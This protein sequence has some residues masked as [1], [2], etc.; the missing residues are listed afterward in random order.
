MKPN[1]ALNITDTAISLLHRTSRGWLEVGSANFDA[2]D[3][4]EAL[5][6][7]RASALG[8]S[9]HGIT[10]K[11]ILPPGQ[12]LYTEVEVTGV[13]KAAREVEIRAALEG[14][15]PYAVED[16]V[17][18]WRGTG[19]VVKVAV[20]ARE[21]LEEAEAFAEAHRFNAVSFVTLPTEG[22]F[23]GEPWFG[24]T[25]GAAS[26]L[27]EGEKVTR[28][29][30][31][32]VV[33]SREAP[34]DTTKA[35][36]T[37][38]PVV[39]APIAEPVDAPKAEAAAAQ[40]DRKDMAEEAAQQAEAEKAAEQQRAEREKAEVRRLAD[41]Q[42]AEAEARARDKADADARAE[43]EAAAEAE[44]LRKGEIARAEMER[45]AQELA[46]AEAKRLVEEAEKN[47]AA[48]L[49]REKSKA[50]LIE[51][52]RK[53]A[54]SE[55]AAAEEAAAAFNGVTDPGIAETNETAPAP[56][57]SFASRRRD[58][59]TSAPSLGPATGAVA[60]GGAGQQLP[61]ITSA[62]AGPA[63]E[64]RI[65]RPAGNPKG[66]AAPAI[67]SIAARG[68]DAPA[69]S[70][71]KPVGTAAG[72]G[73]TAGPAAGPAVA[74]KPLNG[75][76][77]FATGAKAEVGKTS[78]AAA[79]AKPAAKSVGAM[80]TAATIPGTSMALSRFKSKLKAKPA[81]Q[82]A[83]SAARKGSAADVSLDKF[84]AKMTP[85][86]G[87]PRF[88]GLILTL[89]LL[90]L[91]AGVAAWSSIYLSRDDTAPQTVQQA[92]ATAPDG[93]PSDTP[94]DTPTGSGVSDA[95]AVADAEAELPPVQTVASAEEAAAPALPDT[96]AGD[97]NA[98]TATA[99]RSAE[100][101]II[102]AAIDAAQPAFDPVA[103]PRPQTRPDAAP[104]AVSPPP[105]FG[106]QYEFEPD[107]T[108]KATANGVVMPD[109]FW[110]IAARPPVLPPARPAALSD[111]DV[112]TVA[113]DANAAATPPPAPTDPAG[114]STAGLSRMEGTVAG[115]A[116]TTGEGTVSAAGPSFAFE[117]DATVE[118]RR[119]R[120]R[121][122]SLDAVAPA[123]A[124]DDAA[125]TPDAVVA[126]PALVRLASLRPRARPK[127]VV[128]AAEEAR[129]AAVAASL[130]ATAAAEEKTQQDSALTVALSPRP[131]ARPRDF[132]RA[133][134]AAIAAATREA[135]RRVAAAAAAP[136]PKAEAP[137][138]IEEEHEPELKVSAA[139]RIPTHAN[140]AKQATFKS[141][142]NLSKTNLIGVYGSD[143]KRY[144]LIRSA[145]GRYTKVRVGDKVD[146]GT[147]AAITRNEVRYQKGG[148]M[149]SLSMPKG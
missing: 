58:D 49:E 111:P 17:F 95:E 144:A 33:I 148:K 65:D 57:A 83:A 82:P 101:E 11:L 142:I 21:T 78:D 68:P 86:R 104:A 29:Q 94:T 48:M 24:M 100:D 116:N 79:R 99:P 127:A 7:L 27:P 61:K 132:S 120:L 35:P 73:E 131:A 18:D 20:V 62:V 71:P 32:V 69:P 60:G 122:E 63:P 19:S 1:F 124:Q 45:R 107:G 109:G 145:S 96:V 103:L 26:I 70:G 36:E 149:L 119:P 16:L 126:D 128:A 74:R 123:P 143:K 77:A 30:D 28:D 52:E 97:S 40:D 67:T 136:A 3:L 13:D 137:A 47:K 134:E 66:P 87:K 90:G 135:P 14:R 59:A 113:P 72:S 76:A 121:P 108:I 125:V 22:Q 43:A 51:A 37:V 44:A 12:I 75:T 114:A 6:Y 138:D 56:T 50:A 118:N 139:P 80:V 10:T 54:S 106:T 2:S 25:K 4:E 93:A 81:A 98:Q 110:L 38:A 130:A 31:P 115:T 102:L 105:P 53:R 91:L 9:P 147:V 117:Q 46:Q 39:E 55:A 112:P 146:G 5:G 141:A 8:L 15:T 89:I 85:R 92:D 84:A 133:V 129:T 88:L 42:R 64:A 140:V 34:K 41:E 23:A